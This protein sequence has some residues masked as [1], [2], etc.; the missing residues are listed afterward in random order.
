MIKLRSIIFA[1]VAITIQLCGSGCEQQAP[2]QASLTD[3]QVREFA[4][5]YRNE[6][7]TT[8]KS[9][10]AVI[11]ARSTIEEVVKTASG[12]SIRFSIDVSEQPS[13]VDTYYLT[14]FIDLSGTLNKVETSRVVS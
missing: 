3:S 6:W 10:E 1:L 5:K 2:K 11:L 13:E 4:T 9:P 8:H 7:I 14:I 12:W